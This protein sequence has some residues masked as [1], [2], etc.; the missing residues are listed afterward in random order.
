M[1]ANSGTLRTAWVTPRAY[2]PQRGRGHVTAIQESVATYI[3]KLKS[4]SGLQLTIVTA[5]V[6]I[7]LVLRT[8]NMDFTIIYLAYG[9]EFCQV[10]VTCPL[11][12]W[13]P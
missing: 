8:D 5:A 12:F 7:A 13:G 2:R 3:E 11:P 6:R 1:I 9:F 10:L 4:D